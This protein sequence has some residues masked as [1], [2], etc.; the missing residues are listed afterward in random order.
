MSTF[1]LSDNWRVNEG[2]IAIKL[3]EVEETNKYGMKIPTGDEASYEKEAI[4]VKIGLYSP[5]KEF[6]FRLFPW[7]RPYRF[8]VGDSVLL[9]RI[10]SQKF[11][12]P[13]GME[14]M[15]VPFLDITIYQDAKD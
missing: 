3:R 8:K 15:I 14:L 2:R 6:L 5:L 10:P 4:I 7:T 12:T 9:P 1:K 11:T 13:E